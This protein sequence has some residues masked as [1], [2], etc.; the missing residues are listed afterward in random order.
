MMPRLEAR[1]IPMNNILRLTSLKRI[2]LRAAERLSIYKTPN[3]VLRPLAPPP[4]T[5]RVAMDKA[6]VKIPRPHCRG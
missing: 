2:C 4:W 6:V 3:S 5:H 1:C